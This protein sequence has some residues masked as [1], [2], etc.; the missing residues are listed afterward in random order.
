MTLDCLSK[1]DTKNTSNNKRELN[2]TPSKFK[3]FMPQIKKLKTHRTVEIF[4][5]RVSNEE[6]LS[7]IYKELV[8]IIKRQPDFKMGKGCE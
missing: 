4:T 1:Y 7:R 8:I 2:W 5:N 6:L 3:T